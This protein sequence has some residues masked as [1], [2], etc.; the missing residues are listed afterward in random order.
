MNS[1]THATD[2]SH[3]ISLLS[4]RKRL[5]SMF[6]WSIW[7]LMFIG[8]LAFVG[9][10]GRNAPFWDDWEILV[11]ALA[12]KQPITIAWLWETYHEH[13]LPLPKLILLGLGKLTDC[14]FRSGMF[15][16]AC[17]LGL[18]AA[19][20]ILAAKK[21]RG[22]TSYT[23]A[24]FPLILLHWGHWANL[25]FF[26]TV[27]FISTTVLAGAVLSIIA[28]TRG[29]VTPRVAV[30]TTVCLLLLPLTGT[31]G[32]IFVPPLALWLVDSSIRRWRCR[33]S[34]GRRDGLFIFGLAV[35]T[36]LL[37]GLYFFGLRL[38]SFAP[39]ASLL[40]SLRSATKFL[41]TS[42][43]PIAISFWPYSG[44]LVLALLSL[45]AVNLAMAWRGRP[46]ERSRV[47]GLLLFMCAVATLAL[48]IGWGRAALG[49]ER[50]F[51]PTYVTL[52]A[53]TLCVVCF[54]CAIGNKPSNRFAQAG[55]FMIMC[56]LLPFNL[57]DGLENGRSRSQQMGAFVQDL[58]A[59]TPPYLLAERH[60]SFLIPYKMKGQFVEWLRMLRDA[61]IGP[62]RYLP[63][64]PTPQEI[65][66]PITSPAADDMPS[67][68][69]RLTFTVEE[70]RFVYALRL[71]Y[72]CKA[73]SGKVARLQVSWRRDDRKE[74][75]VRLGRSLQFISVFQAGG[76]ADMP[77]EASK[78]ET[79]LTIPIYDNF[80][81]IK[82]LTKDADCVFGL[83]D[84]SLLVPPLERRQADK[85]TE[86]NQG[87]K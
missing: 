47:L 33:E 63:D 57:Q 64:D 62:Y 27:H 36:M 60:V 7:A 21:L 18:L 40:A 23:D 86:N 10:Y 49:E 82:L 31:T 12:G 9:V 71:K 2:T 51:S 69:R 32:L 74:E 50:A 14:D 11:P 81:R 8:A 30:L 73:D 54:A 55:L 78:E 76:G 3:T 37:V 20:M 53:L 45:A 56:L 68:P 72:S 22:W 83:H 25:S 29:P 1:S 4:L 5:A 26:F 65:H 39:H 48:G 80:R 77:L 16:N 75:P 87:P 34:Q 35:V 15:F 66:F 43:G 61:G 19:V 85:A 84:M 38:N 79:A 52:A 59:Q 58:L 24:V 13:R 41:S 46:L 44:L 17:V 28:G 70:P 42:V 6:V 67:D